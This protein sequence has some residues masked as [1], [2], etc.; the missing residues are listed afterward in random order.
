MLDLYPSLMAITLVTFFV[1]LYRLNK[2]LYKPLLKFMDDRD[3][4]ISKDMEVAK[5]MSG[6]TDELQAK[7]KAN[8]DEA[9]ASAAKI[10]Q[11]AIEVGKTRA[12]E[13]IA[14]KQTE[15]DKRQESF[16]TK[17]EK[18][19]SD[20]KNALISQIPL[21]KESLKAKFSQL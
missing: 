2:K 8:L 13:A 15:L 1:M 10:R 7:T 14:L 4:A 21:V 9:K 18:E 17:L 12:S 19:K 16:A 5:N 6:N 20:L 3:T 11:D